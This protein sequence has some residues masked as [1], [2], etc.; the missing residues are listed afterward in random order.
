M[1]KILLNI[2]FTSPLDIRRNFYQSSTPNE[3]EKELRQLLVIEKYNRMKKIPVNGDKV[4]LQDPLN[5]QKN[6][7]LNQLYLRLEDYN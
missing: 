4:K 2:H 3:F 5:L 6:V 7:T 1:E